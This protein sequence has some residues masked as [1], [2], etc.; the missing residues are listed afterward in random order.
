[1]SA[2]QAG[3]G[4]GLERSQLD[5]PSINSDDRRAKRPAAA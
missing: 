3:A 4:G 2:R 5:H 1:M